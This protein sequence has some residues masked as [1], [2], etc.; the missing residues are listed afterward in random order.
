MAYSWQHV[1][2]GMR[3]VLVGFPKWG[4]AIRVAFTVQCIEYCN[5]FLFTCLV[6]R[7][8]RTYYLSSA[9]LNLTE[10]S[11]A[12]KVF[13]S[14]TLLVGMQTSTATVENSVEIP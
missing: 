11:W 3:G 12:L 14:L 8:Y 6:L 10:W 7:N 4:G 9:K 5:G 1:V 2:T 13:H